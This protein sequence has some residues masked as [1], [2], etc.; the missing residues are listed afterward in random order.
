LKLF[1]EE[2]DG[3]QGSYIDE[4]VNAVNEVN[5]DLYTEIKG[6]SKKK[7]GKST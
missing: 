1:D 7:S 4:P 5:G 6:K 3:N 2:T